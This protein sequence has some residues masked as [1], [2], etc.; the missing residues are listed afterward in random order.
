MHWATGIQ[1]LVQLWIPEVTH[2]LAPAPVGHGLRAPGGKSAKLGETTDSERV[3]ISAMVREWSC[4]H[5]C[6]PGDIISDPGETERA[7][8]MGQTSSQP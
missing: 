3:L 6:H 2:E 5:R 7:L 4:W 1:N 8:D